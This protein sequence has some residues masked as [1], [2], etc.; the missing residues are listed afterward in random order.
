[1]G[2][3]DRFIL[4]DHPLFFKLRYRPLYSPGKR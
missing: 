3:R 4:K 2:I 1:M